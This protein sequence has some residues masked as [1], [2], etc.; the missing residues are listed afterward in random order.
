[1]E[2]EQSF[3]KHFFVIGSGT[4]INMIVGFLTTPIITRLVG[5]VEYGQY[6][7]FVMYSSI[8]LM[9][10]CLGLDQ[11]L[12]RYFYQNEDIDFKRTILLE[13]WRIPII[14]TI[15]IGIVINLLCVAGIISFEFDNVVVL[16]LTI[17]VIFQILNRIDLI[18]LR[19]TYQTKM[20]SFLQVVY[21]LSFAVL[22]L[23]GCI[24]YKKNYFYILVIATLVSYIMVVIVGI[25]SQRNLWM[26][27]QRKA[28][29][30]VNRKELYMYAFPYI[31]SMGIT[32]FFQA[33]DKIS[34]NY[35]CS[36]EEVGIYS[37][38]M[39]LIHIFVIVQSTF[40]AM[41]VPTATEHYEKDP[42]DKEYHKRGNRLITVIMFFMGISLILFKDIFALLLGHEYREAAYILPFL[43]FSPMMLTIS[44]TTVVGLIFKKKSH[45]HI[46][47]ASVACVANIIG[48][49]CMVP[50]WGFK[51]AAISTGISYIVFFF[52][53]TIISNRYYHITWKLGRFLAITTVTAFYAWYNTFYS[54]SW[55][56]VIGFLGCIIFLMVL[57]RD[58]VSEMLTIAKKMIEK[59]KR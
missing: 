25:M 4:V 19:V 5:P 48:N 43:I 40:N 26:F 24:V 28:S 32:T 1:M 52:M 44:E 57:Y 54:F 16:L 18:L 20:Y 45:M 39:T 13:C 41:W 35:Y 56:S 33:I 31:I 49:M 14:S 29:I 6:S 38:A 36:Y 47:I 22:A 37:S 3:I 46:V 17:C 7:I 30:R 53:R 42:N 58:T 23:I 12:I 51:G 59:Y 11:A 9:V 2:T 8:A 27:W 10:L 55:I 21:K 50:I 34:L 15:F